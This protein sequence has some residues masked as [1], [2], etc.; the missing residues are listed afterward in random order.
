MCVF[1]NAAN[2]GQPSTSAAV[3]A[4]SASI[5]E[6]ARKSD[7]SKKEKQALCKAAALTFPPV[8]VLVT[9]SMLEHWQPGMSYQNSQHIL[10]RRN[11]EACN[12]MAELV[13]N[14]QK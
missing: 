8:T 2:P 5:D 13:N 10:M 6:M 7:P 4:S 9:R 14:K 11:K 12:R 1:A 3:D